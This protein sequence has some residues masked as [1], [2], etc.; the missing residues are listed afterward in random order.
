[1]RETGEV[2]Y[3]ASGFMPDENEQ[4]SGINPDATNDLNYTHIHN[5]KYLPPFHLLDSLIICP[6]QMQG[7]NG[8]I[9]FFNG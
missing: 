9:P 6:V 3:V 4:T 5:L 7:S 1:M 2:F 8:D